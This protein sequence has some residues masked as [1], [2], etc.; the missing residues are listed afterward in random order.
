VATSV[1]GE[2]TP[3]RG[4]G[5]DDANW[6]DVNFTGQKMKKIHTVDSIATHGW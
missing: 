5:G 4:R 2:A 3:G 6:A 1:G